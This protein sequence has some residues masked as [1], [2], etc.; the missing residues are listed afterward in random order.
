MSLCGSQPDS[1]KFVDEALKAPCEQFDPGAACADLSEIAQVLETKIEATV[2]DKDF[3]KVQALS[4]IRQTL[5]PFT[6]ACSIGTERRYPGTDPRQLRR[7][8]NPMSPRELPRNPVN[9]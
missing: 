4:M 5:D 9:V 2:K 3:S 1:F 8:I 7:G 6:G